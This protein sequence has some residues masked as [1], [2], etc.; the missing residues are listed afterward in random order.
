MK[1]IIHKTVFLISQQSDI[2]YLSTNL[3]FKLQKKT[4]K[5]KHEPA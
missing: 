2:Y 5:A 1:Q 4:F 3:K